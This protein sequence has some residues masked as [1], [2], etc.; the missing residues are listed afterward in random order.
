MSFDEF[1][2]AIAERDARIDQ[3]EERVRRL[4]EACSLVVFYSLPPTDV[5]GN[6]EYERGCALFL[7]HGQTT[8]SLT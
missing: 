2:N 6:A 5:S 1:Q 7:K 3:L 4:I 8:S